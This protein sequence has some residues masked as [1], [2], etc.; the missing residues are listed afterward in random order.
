MRVRRLRT[1]GPE[2]LFELALR[3]WQSLPEDERSSFM[4]PPLTDEQARALLSYMVESTLRRLTQRRKSAL[5]G[6]KLKAKPAKVEAMR[7]EFQA[8]Y[9][10]GQRKYPGRDRD[11]WSYAVGR[12]ARNTGANHRTVKRHFPA[13]VSANVQAIIAGFSESSSKR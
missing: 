13:P 10:E 11:A 5:A 4:L 7:R 9:R 6:L 1:A 2:A 8:A 12:T 3:H